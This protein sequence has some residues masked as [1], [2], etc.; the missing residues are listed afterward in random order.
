[1]TVKEKFLR[2]VQVETTSEATCET[3]PSSPNQLVLANMLVDELKAMGDRAKAI[4][5]QLKEIEKALA[6]QAAA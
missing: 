1:M 3:C 6:Q 5:E 4:D 2:Y